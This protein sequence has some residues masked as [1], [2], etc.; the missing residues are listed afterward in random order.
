M[1]LIYF[2]NIY[3]EKYKKYLSCTIF[4]L[5]NKPKTD[6]LAGIGVIRKMREIVSCQIN[7]RV[8][9]FHFIKNKICIHGY[10]LL[11][12]SSTLY[13]NCDLR[14]HNSNTANFNN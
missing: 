11:Q 12:I 14:N 3:I 4:I 5:R 9:I 10:I 13:F 7:T 1:N 6:K 2:K 8:Y